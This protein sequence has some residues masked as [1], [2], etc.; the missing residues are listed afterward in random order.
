[1]KQEEGGGCFHLCC[2]K[3]AKE[4]YGL[5]L[6]MQ[7]LDVPKMMRVQLG[8]QM[9]NHSNHQQLLQVQPLLSTHVRWVCEAAR[10]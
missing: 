8:S 3:K 2:R 9:Q 4:E 5:L 6:Q 10:G 7:Q 1:M